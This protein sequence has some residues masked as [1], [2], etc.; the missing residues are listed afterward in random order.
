MVEQAP[1]RA[2]AFRRVRVSNGKTEA[3]YSTEAY[4]HRV[5][6]E[7]RS[8]HRQKQLSAPGHGCRSGSAAHEDRA[9]DSSPFAVHR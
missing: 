6:D 1:N 9:L 3:T 2:P 4:D 7:V 5:L 8:S